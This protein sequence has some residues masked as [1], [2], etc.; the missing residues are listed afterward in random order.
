MSEDSLSYPYNE[1]FTSP[2]P[3]AVAR[4]YDHFSTPT[5]LCEWLT[6]RPS[7]TPH[8]REVPGATK[9]IVVVPTASYDGP[10]ARRCR[11]ETFR[12]QHLIFVESPTNPDPFFNPESYLRA[13]FRRALELDPDWIALA[14]DDTLMVDPPRVLADGVARL[15]RDAVDT[16]F[17]RP[18]GYYH[19]L[20]SKLAPARWLR[21]LAYS[22]SST[23]RTVLRAE[24][25]FGVT[26]HAARVKG[27]ESNFFGAGYHH[28]SFAS[29]GI[30]SASYVASHH[31]A[32]FN[33]SFSLGES[34]DVELSLRLSRRPDRYG[35]ID[36]RIEELRGGT[37]GRG[38]DRRLR[39]VAGLAQLVRLLRERP[40][41]YFREGFDYRALLDPSTRSLA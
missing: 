28:L 4:F 34:G 8:L 37:L 35:F 24:S 33:E 30:F 2:D 9:L 39:Q 26:L 38:D 29:F 18:A 22:F 11:A 10:M 20:L 12:G 16:V 21:R 14:G 6:H 40:A 3:H 41:E 19:S 27:W 1:E 7:S 17:T 32:I 23:K 36:Y 5:E 15:D 13:G 31:G 25:K